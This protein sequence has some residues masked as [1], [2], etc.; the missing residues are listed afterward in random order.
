M[1]F[2]KQIVVAIFISLV[3][4]SCNFK[5]KAGI[6]K[7]ESKNESV[8]EVIKKVDENIKKADEIIEQEKL[9][10]EEKNEL[11]VKVK[12]EVEDLV[13]LL[14]ETTDEIE[15][16]ELLKQE[17]DNSNEDIENIYF[18]T[19]KG[20]FY[21]Y[22]EQKLPEG[23]N[24]TNRSWYTQAKEKSEFTSSFTNSATGGE[25]LT[26]SLSVKSEENFIGVLGVDINLENNVQ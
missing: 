19:E 20:M 21:L 5:L 14:S 12:N 2:K 16:K 3:L 13:A 1:K 9:S 24:P 23:F 6:I 10:E 18:A 26:L 7:D 15:I 8:E 17:F 4:T 22:P 25:V 11:A